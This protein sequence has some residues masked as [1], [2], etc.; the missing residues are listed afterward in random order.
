MS[1]N[2]RSRSQARRPDDPDRSLEELVQ[3]GWT[4]RKANKVLNMYS[5]WGMMMFRETY[6]KGL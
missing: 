1:G 2:G 5:K 3:L 6:N 4:K